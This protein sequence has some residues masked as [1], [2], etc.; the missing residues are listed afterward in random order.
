[1]KQFG[2]REGSANEKR[3]H[4]HGKIKGDEE[5]D[6]KIDEQGDGYPDD[7]QGQQDNHFAL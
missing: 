2:E 1:V 4:L 3:R 7:I 5:H 6:Y